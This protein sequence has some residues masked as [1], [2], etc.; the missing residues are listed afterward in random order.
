MPTLEAYP[1]PADQE[2]RLRE[3]GGFEQV[4]CRTMDRIWERWVSEGEKRRVDEV[5]GGLDEVEEWVLLAGHY[6]VAWGWKGGKMDLDVEERG[7]DGGRGG[8]EQ[9]GD[10]DIN[11]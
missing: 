10:G 5:E 8:G 2:R 3:E 9:G 11:L 4:R 7:G 6:V 1:T